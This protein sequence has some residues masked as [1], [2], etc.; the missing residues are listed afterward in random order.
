M[1]KAEFYKLFTAGPVLLDGATGSNLMKMGMPRGVCTE[2]WVAEHPETILELQ[3]AYAK[4]GSQIVYAPTFSANRHSLARHGMADRVAELNRA[5]VR[6]SKQVEGVLVAGDMTT[7]GVPM[8]PL[9]TMNYNEL[10]DI[11]SEQA[12]ALS[13]AGAD[14]IVVETMLGVD[15][16]SA[17]LEAIQSVCDLPVMC[18]VSIQADGGVY[19]GGTCYDAVTTLEALGASAVGI[20]CSLGP[21]QLPAIVR[22]LKELIQI[23]LL[24]KPNAG[25]PTI[26]DQGEAIYPM[27]PESFAGHMLKLV[28]CGAN[29]I[30][31]CCGT[32]PDYIAAVKKALA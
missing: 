23:P 8:E 20:N 2:G 17:A 31:G 3:R 24:V 12:K 13:E 30:G 25:M 27:D 18:R 11:Y 14:L 19:F 10:F 7:T 16:T 15:E 26:S 21:E 28:D 4:A 9:G 6:I 32:S 5:L 1:T 22:N 29:F